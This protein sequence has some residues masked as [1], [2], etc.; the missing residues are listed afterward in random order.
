[1]STTNAAIAT[2]GY[3]TI[4]IAPLQQLR[5]FLLQL[6]L[7][8]EPRPVKRQVGGGVEI[9]LPSPVQ[10]LPPKRRPRLLAIHRDGSVVRIRQPLSL[11]PPPCQERGCLIKLLHPLLESRCHL[12]LRALQRRCL[13]RGEMEKSRSF[14]RLKLSRTL[15]K[16]QF[17]AHPNFETLIWCMQLRSQSL[18]AVALYGSFLLQSSDLA[19]FLVEMAQGCPK[20]TKLL[21][22]CCLSMPSCPRIDASRRQASLSRDITYYI[23]M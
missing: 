20:I 15:Q 13:P 22:S 11:R 12:P 23:A 3:F 18:S 10:Q 17:W 14:E 5:R 16:I 2:I 9:R 21:Y 19:S 6:G 1:L 8:L 4:A 7:G